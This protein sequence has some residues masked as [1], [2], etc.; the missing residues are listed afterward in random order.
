MGYL[1][2]ISMETNSVDNALQ[3]A[4]NSYEQ[5]DNID[6][7][8][9]INIRT[10]RIDGYIV[11]SDMSVVDVMSESIDNDI[12]IYNISSNE[13]GTATCFSL[14]PGY[15]Y[16]KRYSGYIPSTIKVGLMSVENQKKV[17]NA[18]T[19]TVAFKDYIKNTILN[20]LS[21]AWV[22]DHAEYP[23]RKSG[24]GAQ[25][26]ITKQYALWY[27][28]YEYEYPDAGV[29]LYDIPEKDQN[30]TIGGYNGL[31]T[32]YK[33]VIDDAIDEYYKRYI[34]CREYD[35]LFCT[36]YRSTQEKANTVIYGCL[37]QETLMSEADAGKTT[38]TILQYAY[39]FTKQE[40]IDNIGFIT[41]K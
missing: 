16:T 29:D 4:L 1:E 5:M 22:A 17:N 34:L 33:K 15:T 14:R 11:D 31:A 21:P 30:F 32:R 10:A 36:R 3:Y 37:A 28:I 7:R 12:T 8:T 27:T 13:N 9:A 19:Y 35:S 20:E 41:Y 23:N 2:K 39:Q 38:G 6:I 24:Y 18:T 25:L 40:G 26:I